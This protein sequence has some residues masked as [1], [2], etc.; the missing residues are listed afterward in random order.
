MITFEKLLKQS[1]P[2]HALNLRDAT[3]KLLWNQQL[4]H[5]CDQYLYNAHKYIYGVPNFSH[6]TS[7]VL[8][9]FTGVA[10]MALDD[11]LHGTK[12]YVFT[13][14]DII[15]I[16]PTSS[17]SVNSLFE[18]RANASLER[19]Y[20]VWPSRG[21]LTLDNFWSPPTSWRW[22]LQSVLKVRRL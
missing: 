1:Y 19:M 15:G 5:P 3:E 12:I 7:K 6:F 9:Y 10:K 4:G 11:Q 14:I 8:E 20:L 2:I 13:S 21:Y 22:R 16:F 17:G 18:N